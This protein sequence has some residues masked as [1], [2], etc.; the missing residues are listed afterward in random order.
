[1]GDGAMCHDCRRYICLCSDGLLAQT[2]RWVSGGAWTEEEAADTLHV[3]VERW[4][5]L[6][7]EAKA[8]WEQEAQEWGPRGYVPGDSF[9][10]FDYKRGS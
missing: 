5:T 9:S 10:D 8:R 6:L 2:S 4:R 7:A 3:T 1:M